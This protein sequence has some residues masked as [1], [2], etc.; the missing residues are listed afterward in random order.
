M[1]RKTEPIE[2]KGES[3]YIRAKKYILAILQKRQIPKSVIAE[4]ML[5]FEALFH[6]ILAQK[7]NADTP[8]AILGRERLGYVS[9][10]FS[11]EGGMYIPGDEEADSPEEKILLAYSD[12]IDYSY[13]LG[14]NRIRI[15]LRNS[16]AKALLPCGIALLLAILTFFLLYFLGDK[17]LT[18]SLLSNF[19]LPL[20]SLFGN[21]MLM[22]GAPVTFLSLLK[23]L[24]NAYIVSEHSREIRMLRWEIFLSSLIT[25]LLAVAAALLTA[26]IVSQPL[27][28]TAY[29]TMKVAMT[30]PDFIASL[31]P[32]DI[33][34]PFQMISPFPLIIVAVIITCALCSVGGHFDGLKRALDAG[35]A[36]FSRILGI[37]MSVLP[38]F[39]FLAFLHMLLAEGVPAFL[40]MAELTLAVLLG[41]T[42]VAM[43]YW[44]RLKKSG[45]RVLEFVKK[46]GPL[47]TEN[48]LI[49]SALDAAPFNIRYCSRVYH[50]DRKKLTFSIPVLAQIN[51]DGNCFIITFLSLVLMLTSRTAAAP[52]QPGSCLIG[53]LIILTYM[54][55]QDL[56]PLAIF[57]EVAFGSLQNLINVT[58][59]IITAAELDRKQKT[60]PA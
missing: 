32:S 14:I 48:F 54:N 50:M 41:L 56:I 31:V 40:Y 3:D 2:I 58:G 15:T 1:S 8:V 5:V 52:N 34:A 49:G 17:S 12:K 46:M 20:E 11:F 47:L 22:V 4:S 7:K 29:R 33:F 16:H 27:S 25:V 24:T 36:L 9:I 6:E 44:I 59:D 10:L 18:D 45:I 53:L 26:G 13:Q 43:F 37:I 39:V 57:S 19:V 21:A 51:L 55:A 60:V 23:N 38:V 35:Y 28:F 30:L 42:L